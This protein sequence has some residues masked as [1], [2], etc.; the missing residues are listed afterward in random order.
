[1]NIVLIMSDTFRYDNLGCN[2]N[3]VIDTRDLDAFAKQ[4]AVF[5]NCYTGSFPTLPQR[6]DMVTG[7]FV[8]PY[9][10]WQALE[11]DWIPVAEYLHGAGYVTQL[12]CDTPHLLSRNSNFYRGFD[13]YL[14]TRGQESDTP[15]TRMNDPI[16]PMMDHKKTRRDYNP[17]HKPSPAPGIPFDATLLDRHRW[18]NRHWRYEEDRFMMKTGSL[19]E[20]WLEEN[21]AC[22]N[23][24]L[25][26]D[27]F[28]AHEPWDPP[29]YL[30]KRYDP[31][32][33]GPPM[34][35]PNYGHASDYTAAEIKNMRAHYAGE[36]HLVSKAIGR[37][38]RKV[39]ETGLME[40]TAIIFTS[41]HG[42]AIGEHDMVGKCNINPKDNRVWQLYREVTHVPLMI[43]VPG[44]KPR[45]TNALAQ[46]VDI[47]PTILEL[48]GHKIPGDIDGISLCDVIRRKKN[49][50]RNY[51]IS[52]SAPITH[53]KVVTVQDKKYS[54]AIAGKNGSEVELFDTQQDPGQTKNLLK[55]QPKEARRLLGY[56]NSFLKDKGID[57]DVEFTV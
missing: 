56:L 49:S 46:P 18:I 2:G 9:Y 3:R 28:D 25:W 53:T 19:A 24:F 31:D 11:P 33:N 1:M 54:L 43:Y 20:K 5:D 15:F 42:H 10:G 13:A 21:Y 7:R 52:A 17:G 22:K 36:A 48:A 32:Y 29:E 55:K 14:W 26:V 41:D 6:T 57:G 38:I 35:H 12:L 30:V 8:F 16:R 27:M 50:V 44:V 51:A 4:C 37:I 23:F 39:E 47:M 45:R 34:L 40:N